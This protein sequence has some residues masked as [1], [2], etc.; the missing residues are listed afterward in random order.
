MV[1]SDELSA[2]CCIGLSM[3]YYCVVIYVID[4]SMMLTIFYD[5]FKFLK[6]LKKNKIP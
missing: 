3:C 2:R 5:F 6:Q 1:H 4:V